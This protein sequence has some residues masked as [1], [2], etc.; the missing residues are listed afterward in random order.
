MEKVK[1]QFATETGQ[2][3][4]NKLSQSSDTALPML[5]KSRLVAKYT[6][7]TPTLFT[8]VDVNHIIQRHRLKGQY[9]SKF[10]PMPANI[11]SEDYKPTSSAELDQWFGPVTDHPPNQCDFETCDGMQELLVE[12]QVKR[13]KS[14]PS[15]ISCQ[16]L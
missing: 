15:M 10:V 13:R 12:R 7:G 8:A 14:R 3:R 1:K 2:R 16:L 9:L 11:P 5:P 4:K 6:G